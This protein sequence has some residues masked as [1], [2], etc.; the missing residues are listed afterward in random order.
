MAKQ[1]AA[2]PNKHGHIRHSRSENVFNVFNICLMV[3]LLAF[4]LYPIFNMVSISMSNEYAVLRGEVTFYPR[5]FNFQAY[6]LIF[7]SKE[8]WRSVLNS[9]FV[10][11]VGTATGLILMS[12][13]A[14][15]LAFGDFYGKKLYNILILLTMWFSAGIIPLFLTMSQLK[16]IN[17]LWA[18]IFN[19]MLTAYNVV[20][21]RSYFDS[22]PMSIIESARIDGAN[23]FRILFRFVMPLAKPVLATVALW[24]IVSHWNDFLHPLVFV[25]TRENYTLQLMLNEMVLSAESSVHNI[26]VANTRTTGGAAA[27]GQQTRN[28]VLV[29]AM[30]PMVILYPFVQRFFIGGVMLGSVKG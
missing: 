13:A 10:A 12:M 25:S 15:P 16:L 27:L 28:A 2:K 21:I 9:T 24:V 6:R 8:L 29:V 11:G 26:S 17:S 23:D 14:Y 1:I 18:L 4:F 7:E 19:F 3:V 22:I 5:G 30:I 20:I